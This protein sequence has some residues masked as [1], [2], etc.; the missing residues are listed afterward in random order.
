MVWPSKLL[1]DIFG[2]QT[3]TSKWTSKAL[4]VNRIFIVAYKTLKMSVLRALSIALN[5]QLKPRNLHIWLMAIFGLILQS[6]DLLI[7]FN[8]HGSMR[9]LA[10]FVIFMT[11]VSLSQTSPV[12]ISFLIPI[13]RSK[14]AIFQKHL[15]FHWTPTR[16]LWMIMGLPP[17]LTLASLGQLCMKLWLAT[18]VKLTSSKITLPPMVE[19]IGQRGSSYQVH[20][21][22][23]LVGSLNAAGMENFA[24][25][26]VCCEHWILS[27]YAFLLEPSNHAPLTFWFL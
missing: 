8:L 10:H 1:W 3:P 21:V 26:T 16:R 7:S 17:K 9:W 27:I 23:G 14:S 19:P 22:S 12:E 25:P 20:R 18:S 4:G 5:V 15:S 6:T 13:Y 11:D 24:T 2:A